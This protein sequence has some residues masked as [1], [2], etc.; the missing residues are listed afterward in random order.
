MIVV[1]VFICQSL[2]AEVL[3]I[4]LSLGYIL[5][6][7]LCSS[8]P[9]QSESHS[10]HCI[11]KGFPVLGSELCRSGLKPCLVDFLASA[12]SERWSRLQAGAELN[13]FFPRAVGTES[14][15]S[16]AGMDV[17]SCSDGSSGVCLCPGKVRPWQQCQGWVDRVVTSARLVSALELFS[18]RMVLWDAAG[19]CLWHWCSNSNLDI[20]QQAFFTQILEAGKNP[21]LSILCQIIIDS[22]ESL[23]MQWVISLI[24][25]G[26]P[27]CSSENP[28]CWGNNTFFFFHTGINSGF[29]VF[30]VWSVSP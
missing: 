10:C 7:K 19:A 26:G 28:E 12:I 14:L 18:S 27:R 3:L 20:P 9:S 21:D 23:F 30:S 5:F 16:C 4:I 6:Y 24:S 8:L 2:N 1:I 17:Q 15:H 29:R 25:V 11:L 22:G 13:S